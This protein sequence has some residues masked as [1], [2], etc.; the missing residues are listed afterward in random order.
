MSRRADEEQGG[1]HLREVRI[2]VRGLVQG[3]GFRPTVWRLAREEGLV[4][5]VLNDGGGVVIEARGPDSA[6]SAFLARL[7][8]EPPRLARI[9]RVTVRPLAR[10]AWP[11]T[12]TIAP[13]HA[14][15]PTTGV[16]P[17]AALCDA[18]RED[19]LGGGADGRRLRYP[20]TN[21]TEC[22]PR[23]S[24]V[25]AIPYD[26][27]NTTMAGFPLCAACA[28]EY[29][30]PTDRRFHAQ[31]NACWRCGPRVSLVGVD[32]AAAARVAALRADPA[33]RDDLDVA[34][35]LLAD[36]AIVAVKGLGGFHLACDATREDVVERLRARKRRPRKALALMARDLATIRRYARVDAAEAELL[37]SPQ[38]PIVLLAPEGEGVAPSIAPGVDT[39]GFMLPYTPLHVL[40]L[41]RLDRP[42]VMTSGN[43]SDAPQLTEDAEAAARLAP[44]ADAILSHDRPI[45]NRVDDSV[46]RVFAGGPR[47]LRRARGYAPSPL[48]LP[49]GLD[50]PEAPA[51]LAFGG[52]LKA[53]FCLADARGAVLSPHLGDLEDVETWHD[54][55]RQLEVL[56]ALYGHRPALVVADAHPEYLSTKLAAARAEAAGLPL[57]HVQHHRA[58][59][60]SCL[61]DHG[62]AL[63]APPLVGVVLDGL[64]WGEDDTFWGGEVFVG[65]YRRLDRV[66]RLVPVAMPGGARAIEEP[67]RD[68]FAHLV[69]AFGSWGAVRE[70]FGDLA[71]VRD[72]DARPVA[73]LE[74]MIARGVRAPRASSAGRLFDAVAA[75][76]GLCRDR[77]SFEG[78]AGMALEAAATAAVRGGGDPGGAYV[79]ER[80]RAGALR[81]L[82]PRPMWE[83]LL[84]DLRDGV[85]IGVIAARFHHGLAAALADLVAAVAPAPDAQV[86]LSGGVFQNAVL[87]EA[88]VARLTDRG[89]RPLVHREIPPNDG[90]V[91][92]G[93]A[94]LAIARA[95]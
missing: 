76:V 90:G 10:G 54:Y 68:A 81:E 34:A 50:V 80:A 89:L 24:I 39:V 72:L 43:L 16:V 21:C 92:L 25:R 86:A 35:A 14:S 32:E 4:G 94:A 53:T 44:I 88:L 41:E 79:F 46:A 82:S 77:A 74:Q 51:V 42:L 67:W 12:F 5:T 26:R 73:I 93:Q 66:A 60:A 57:V 20:F 22:G 63:D 49:P 38:A 70:R 33:N 55:Q 48:A 47:V 8:A 56:T 87:T 91:A 62:V 9:D 3:V 95:L 6:V 61:V 69:A 19:T 52:H 2:R 23:Y 64:G 1:P 40:L 7:E 18:C 83:R 85:P 59:V 58:H 15:D 71:L 17:D 78:E 37:A 30:A 75:A 28:A 65:G 31:P 45:A 11:E 29:G 27:A 84:A 36:G 13:S